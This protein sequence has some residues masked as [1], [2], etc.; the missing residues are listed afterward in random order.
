MTRVMRQTPLE[1]W[2]DHVILTML[3]VA[4][5]FGIDGFLIRTTA[6]PPKHRKQMYR[7]KLA[8]KPKPPVIIK[9]KHRVQ[10]Y[11]RKLQPKP[12]PPVVVKT[13]HGA[14]PLLP[15]F[16]S[17][18]YQEVL[19][20]AIVWARG[21][22]TARSETPAI[23]I[24]KIREWT[25]YNTMQHASDPRPYR[26]YQEWC[27]HQFPA[28]NFESIQ[29]V[30]QSLEKLGLLVTEQDPDCRDCKRYAVDENAVR[31]LVGR[32]AAAHPEIAARFRG[33]Q[34]RLDTESPRLDPSRDR[35][36]IESGRLVNESH[37]VV[38]KESN[39]FKNKGASPRDTLTLRETDNSGFEDQSA[40]S[41]SH[42]PSESLQSQTEDRYASDDAHQDG[43][44]PPV[45]LAP[46]PQTDSG[47][48]IT[49]HNQLCHQ[50]NDPVAAMWIKAAQLR[51]YR[52]IDGMGVYTVA[53]TSESAKNGLSRGYYRK[54]ESIFRGLQHG[55]VKIEFEVGNG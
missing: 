37:K 22:G 28:Q 46:L 36:G 20:A 31:D 2:L 19:A 34:P 38:K 43:P 1:M 41:G 53:V 12:R 24:Q 47:V 17:A 49:A 4:S 50:L 35:L 10:M 16:N 51:E 39:Q 33:T 5:R 55:P 25:D 29:R 45:P 42:P 13:H 7:L 6:V 15:D 3:F 48:W 9:I 54:I 30:I 14:A 27:D 11:R 32:W 44:I 26:S 40:D 52:C 8:P 18:R 23:F 21:K